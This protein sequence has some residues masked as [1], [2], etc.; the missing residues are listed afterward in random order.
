MPGGPTAAPLLADFKIF[1]N[2]PCPG[3][4][5][6]GCVRRRSGSDKRSR[7]L[8]VP[9]ATGSPSNA[10]RALKRLRPSKPNSKTR[11]ARLSMVSEKFLRRRRVTGRRCFTRL[12][13]D[14]QLHPPALSEHSGPP[15]SRFSFFLHSLG[16]F[17]L[18]FGGVFEGRDPQL[19]T[20]GLSGCRVKPRRLWGRQASHDNPCVLH[21]PA[22]HQICC[23]HP[24]GAH[25]SGFPP[26]IVASAVVEQIQGVS[27]K[28]SF[29]SS[30]L[31]R[32]GTQHG[33]LAP[34]WRNIKAVRSLFVM[35]KTAPRP[36]N[37]PAKCRQRFPGR[38]PHSQW[39]RPNLDPRGK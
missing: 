25:F 18:N 16:V 22:H 5:L 7:V 23:S 9:G 24:F 14:Q 31:I 29:P 34:L 13:V 19:C 32:G 35:P 36:P 4:G 38:L 21:G 15:F 30:G 20:F 17:S 8:W 28:R 12:A 1:R 2:F 10:W 27:R 37:C 33:R 26:P 6:Y 11:A 3:I 39:T